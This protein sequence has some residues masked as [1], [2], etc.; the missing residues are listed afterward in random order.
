MRETNLF[1]I[2]CKD[3][4]LRE[5]RYEDLDDIHTLT[6]QPEIYEF[7]TG[8]NVSKEQR[9][10]WLLN[11][12]LKENQ[13]FL[14]AVAK[15]GDVKDLRLRLGIILKETGAFIGWCCTGM[16]DISP[17]PG[18]EI[19]Y[20]ISKSHR[21]KGYTTQAAQ[22]LIEYLFDNTNVQI[23]I[24]I[25]LIRN[26]PSNRVIQKCGFEFQSVFEH[27]KKKFNYYIMSKTDYGSKQIGM[28]SS[29]QFKDQSEY[30]ASFNHLVKLVFGF[31]F[32]AWYQK[33]YWDDRYICHSIIIGNQIVAN[34]SV[35]K[36]DLVING[37]RKKAIQIGTVMTHP[38]HR[39]KGLS[40]QLMEQVLNTYSDLC[41][42]IF[43]FANHT[44][45][46]FYPK[47]GFE[48]LPEHQFYMNVTVPFENKGYLDKLNISKRA[49][50]EFIDQM[51]CSHRSVSQR[52]GV[53]NNDGL[54][55]FYAL[56]VYPE[57][58][59]YSKENE[60][61]IVYEQEGELLHLYDVVSKREVN[62]QLLITRISTAQTRKIQFHLTPDQLADQVYVVPKDRK[63]DVLFVKPLSDLGELLPFCVPKLAHT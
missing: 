55:H 3:I 43:L 6:W 15:D 38:E 24:A 9:K 62:M 8:W 13:Q 39:G 34:V 58:L 48:V 7:L 2:E 47:F 5:Y 42:L 26:T 52:F 57:C 45:L 33:G 16:L 17:H 60:A 10:E 36:M 30:R 46:D 32:E 53:E 41:D 29:E 56:N 12:E 22:G 27:E 51:L 1:T 18:R 40:K 63:E 21:N 44:V 54:F 31:D 61:I 28:I 49:D 59:Y 19:M 11:Y 23:L 4:I 35:S 25:A 37:A 50:R 20:G 14:K